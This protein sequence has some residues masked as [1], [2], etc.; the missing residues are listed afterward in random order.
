MSIEAISVQGEDFVTS[1]SV[2]GQIVI[3]KEIRDKLGLM[4]R[5]KF[6]E[7]IQGKKI[8]LE[9]LPSLGELG[10]SWGKTGKTTKELMKEVDEGWDI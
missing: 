1:M 6:K 5:V 9:P 3:S 4:P 8:I 10:G 7:K 2:K